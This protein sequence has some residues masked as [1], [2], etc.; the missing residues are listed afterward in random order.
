MKVYDKALPSPLTVEE[1]KNMGEHIT[2]ATSVANLMNNIDDDAAVDPIDIQ[3]L[4]ELLRALLS[5]PMEASTELLHEKWDAEEG[6][7]A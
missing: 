7:K 2:I 3:N 5:H 4:G 6:K 1:T